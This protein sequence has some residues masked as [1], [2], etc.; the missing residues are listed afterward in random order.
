[1]TH[2]ISISF[3]RK[4]VTVMVFTITSAAEADLNGA[5]KALREVRCDT[6]LQEIW[7][8]A[9]TGNAEAHDI[10]GQAY[11]NG[12][13][14]PKT[15]MESRYWYLQAA[16]RGNAHAQFRLSVLYY[17]AA[18]NEPKFSPSE[19]AEWASLSAE[20]G[21][22]PAQS[23][24]GFSLANGFGVQKNLILGLMWLILAESAGD[25][26]EGIKRVPLQ[27]EYRPRNKNWMNKAMESMN[28]GEIKRSQDLA[29]KWLV[30]FKKRSNTESIDSSAN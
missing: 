5:Y 1:M 30:R 17:M 27:E 24:I 15:Y 6:A 2:R 14:L 9:E 26:K 10:L 23:E 7:E 11:E 13:C 22:G 28:A 29:Y 12:Y 25:D 20:Q 3:F 16:K 4:I 21:Y 8:Q 19:R 18:P